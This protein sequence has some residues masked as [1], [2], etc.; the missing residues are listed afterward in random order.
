MDIR[1]PL[2]SDQTR[3]CMCWRSSTNTECFLK[4]PI[5]I[6]IHDP[7]AEY[8]T[9]EKV[10]ELD[11]KLSNLYSAMME[12]STCSS[13]PMR[14]MALLQELDVLCTLYVA[15]Q[16]KYATTDNQIKR[17]NSDGRLELRDSKFQVGR[18]VLDSEESKAIGRIIVK[19]GLDHLQKKLLIVQ[20]EQKRVN[21]GS[22]NDEIGEKVRAILSKVWEA[23]AYGCL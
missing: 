22:M 2:S 7:A 15:A 11:Q 8:N 10:L 3:Q 4:D 5:G 18:F 21:S 20:A 19:Q 14:A 9:L 16:A 12:C 17:G 23:S 6:E 13:D 1:G